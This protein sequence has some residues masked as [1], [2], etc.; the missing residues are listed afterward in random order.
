MSEGIIDS[1]K[2]DPGCG[3][4]QGST[5][6]PVVKSE[7]VYSGSCLGPFKVRNASVWECPRCGGVKMLASV[8]KSWERKKA[9]EVIEA[10]SFFSA[11]E[12]RFMR[13]LCG[14][15]PRELAVA[16][17]V[18]V[19]DVRKWEAGIGGAPG[20][21]RLLARYVLRTQGIL[22]TIE[23]E[24]AARVRTKVRMESED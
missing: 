12:M 7:F 1:G 22:N 16:L 14:R 17:D 15:S 24:R 18:G 19:G 13:E 11:I 20:E 23:P 5:G 3:K 2:G 9:L 10:N 4:C 6:Q 21:S 8:A